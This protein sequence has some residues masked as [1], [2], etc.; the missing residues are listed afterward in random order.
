MYGRWDTP[1]PHLAHVTCTKK[2]SDPHFESSVS[3]P[4]LLSN[5]TWNT[6][7]NRII[8]SQELKELFQKLKDGLCADSV[9]VGSDFN[10]MFL[11]TDIS[12]YRV[13][14]TKNI[15]M[16]RKLHVTEILTYIS[17]KIHTETLIYILWK[18]HGLHAAKYCRMNAT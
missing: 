13:T 17:R 3:T 8:W 18:I 14:V 11:L 1:L 10:K 12:Y 5:L 2:K 15:C 4:V 9:L 16:Y 6:E 7:S